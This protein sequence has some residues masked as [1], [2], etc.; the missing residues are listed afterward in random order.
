VADDATSRTV[1]NV[2]D[3]PGFT[4]LAAAEYGAELEL[5]VETTAIAVHCVRC[6]RRAFAHGRRER[7]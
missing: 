2:L 5:L 1:Q 7:S 6:E 4:V 3:L